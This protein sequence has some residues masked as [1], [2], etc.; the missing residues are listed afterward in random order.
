[1][2]IKMK[3][4]TRSETKGLERGIVPLASP[5]IFIEVILTNVAKLPRS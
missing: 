1:M 4:A 2:Q 5:E 3:L